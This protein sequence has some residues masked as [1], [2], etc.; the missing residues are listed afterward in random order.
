MKK[1][2]LGALF[3]GLM[4][5]GSDGGSNSTVV[6]PVDGGGDGGGPEICNPLTQTGCNS[7]EKCTWIDDQDDPTPIGHVGCAPEA[8][9]PKAEGEAC[10]R[11]PAGPMGYDD[12]AKGTVCLSGECKKICDLNAGSPMCD[13]DHSCTR[14]A[15]F[16]ES[17]G[18]AV[19][20]VCDPSCDPL[21]QRL[22]VGDQEACGSTNPGEPNK[23]CY[24]FD[25]Y[26]CAPVPSGALDLLDRAQ[27]LA[28]N[29]NPYLNGCAPGF[30]P[31]F[32]ESSTSMVTKCSGLCAALE[33]DN[34]PAHMNNGKGDATA[35][36]K[37]PREAEPLAERATCSAAYKGA[38]SGGSSCRFIYPYL[39]DQ[40][41]G[42]LPPLFE[43]SVYLDTLGVCFE[44]ASFPDDQGNIDPDCGT[45]TPT[46]AADYGCQ[47]L[48]SLPDSFT[49][50]GKR[51]IPTSARVRLPTEASVKIVR[52]TF[53]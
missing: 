31:F 13:A 42:E 10:T 8:A 4:A 32:Y 28:Q 43:N 44:A 11:P 20:G 41:T 17:G 2:A 22:K 38:S 24:G 35:L 6:I 36:G 34:T 46:E 48:S 16:F 1:H 27:P 9:T 26:S 49:V 47:K 15:D 33:T 3:L 29:G 5:C 51:R 39:A 52:H 12:C 23:G 30:I 19:A 7:G 25:D 37:M 21:T 53:R 45:L 18:V 14:Y 40:S 50:N